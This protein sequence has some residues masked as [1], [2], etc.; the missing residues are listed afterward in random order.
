MCIGIYPQFVVFLFIFLMMSDMSGKFQLGQAHAACCA[1]S[2][3][4]LCL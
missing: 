4:A 2:I 3:K 1:L